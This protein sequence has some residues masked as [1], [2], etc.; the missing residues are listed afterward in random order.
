LITISTL[1][2]GSDKAAERFWRLDLRLR[3]YRATHPA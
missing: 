2:D 1:P 3:W